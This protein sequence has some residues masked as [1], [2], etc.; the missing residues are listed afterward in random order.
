MTNKLKYAKTLW[1]LPFAAVTVQVKAH[2]VPQPRQITINGFTFTDFNGNNRLDV[3]EDYRLPLQQRINDLVS[4]M[5]DDEK[6][7]FLCGTG[8][9]GFD[10]ITPV[11]GAVQGRVPGAA[12]TTYA[13][14]RLGIPAII[15]ADGPA[16]LRIQPKREGDTNTYYCTAFPVGTALASSWNT[17]LVTQVGM[18]MGNEVKEYG[19]DVL[20]APALNIH[21]NPLCGRNFEYYSEDP[22]VSGKIAAAMV[23]GIQTNGVGTSIK[24]F[25][26]NNQET[27]RLSINEHI[28]ERAMREIYLRNFEIAV[29]ESEPW[30]VM[31][32]YNLVNGTYTSARKDLLTDILRT[33]WGYKGIV[34]TDWFGGYAGF[35]SIAGGKASNVVAQENAGND[36]LMPGMKEQVAAL[37]QAMKNGSI[38]KETVDQNVGRILE[39]VLKSPT[40]QK[41]QYSNKP[42]LSGNA[43]IS[44]AAAAEGMVLLKNAEGALPMAAKKK[45][46]L[47]GVTSY[48][49]ISGGTG[50]GDV[51]EAYTV[52]LPDA[53]QL[54]NFK[55]DN[56]L[57]AKYIPFAAK[58]QADEIARREKEGGILGQP[59]RLPE[60]N[61]T[62]ADINDAAQQNDYAVITIGRN[63][64]E[65]H[66]RTV[67][68]D[69]N[70][71]ADEL[72]LINDVSVAFRAQ[73]KKVVVLLNVGGVVETESW[74]AKADAILVAWQPGQE[75]GN[76]VADVLSG[77]INPS[78]KLT[79]SFP[80][81]YEDVPSAKNFP[82]T[83]K[84]NPTEVTYTEGIY[85]GYRYYNTFG[86]KTSY[87]FGYGASYT[88]F[89]YTAIKASAKTLTD[90]ITIAVT[91]KNSGKTAGKEVVQLYVSA[92]GKSMHKPK[93]ELKAF[94]K[95]KLLQPGENEVLTFTLSAKDIASFQDGKSAW[96]AEPGLYTVKAAASSQDARKTPTFT[97]AKES[98]A[99]KVHHRFATDV[100]IKE[101]R[102]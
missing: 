44:R 28:S 14:D 64:G 93:Q 83:P 30:T 100:T 96:V 48:Q 38:K 23:N 94:G 81:K 19:V 61:L 67:D 3:Y 82:G 78:G 60:L 91:V 16:G 66:D 49:F 89:E 42:N 6:A 39:L 53:L 4:Q 13:I 18:A 22:V 90:N 99:E 87:P 26:A 59:K 43:E 84:D 51:N 12:G 85:V 101:L 17:T 68:N 56:K 97:V 33:E 74:K 69:F 77:K 7:H 88:T 24:H 63:S 36:L 1:L 9:P 31:S 62:P 72:K 79:M 70:L 41:Y 11:A 58:A 98:I 80:V 34:M 2:T 10:G 86:V 37:L 75:A 65:Q 92:P 8:M 76:A 54:A 21:R 46:A 52:S 45:V 50:S 29:R 35:E 57:T 20:L 102:P 71:G 55:A 95:T 5:T 25:A 15:L 32:S 47:F 40:M 73:K 27:N